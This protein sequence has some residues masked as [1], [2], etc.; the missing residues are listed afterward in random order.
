MVI[1]L[2]IKIPDFINDYIEDIKKYYKKIKKNLK[3]IYRKCKY[4]WNNPQS[5]Y[6]KKIIPIVNLLILKIWL[7]INNILKRIKPYFYTFKDRL[8]KIDYKKRKLAIIGS[9]VL[10]NFLLLR[11]FTSFAI[12]QNQFEFSILGSK[13]GDKFLNEFDY[14]LLIYIEDVDT[15]GSASGKYNLTSEVPTFGYVYSGYKCKND[16]TLVFDEELKFTTVDLEKKDVCSVYFNLTQNS[17]I[18]LNVFLEEKVNSNQYVR[19]NNL[20]YFGYKYSHYECNN[21]SIINYNSTLH[22]VSV[23]ASKKDNCKIFFKKEQSDIEVILFV[24]NSTGDYIESL[25][26]PS[27]N[28]Y[29][30]NS[31]NSECLN[32]NNERVNA[33]IS[34]VDGYI[35]IVTNEIA[36]CKVYLD[37]NNE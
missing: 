36:Y 37:L 6:A 14:T 13:V 25:T 7:G 34:Y 16:S 2:K 19:S 5:K 30:L 21:G 11:L 24:E 32:T 10:I 3:K 22:K 26:I 20:P 4:H 18:T 8:L 17:D 9:I 1:I 31:S 28:N 33:E 12:Y 23:E 35:G 15:D 29:K 27:G